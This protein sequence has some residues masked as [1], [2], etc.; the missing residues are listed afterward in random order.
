MVNDFKRIVGEESVAQ[1]AEGAGLSAELCACSCVLA[2]RTVIVATMADNTECAE[3]ELFIA[4]LSLDNRI[5]SNGT[6]HS[7]EQHAEFF[8]ILRLG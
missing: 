7:A 5:R 6:Q 2:K 3:M 8:S 4:N 1:L